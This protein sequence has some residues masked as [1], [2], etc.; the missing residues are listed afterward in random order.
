MTLAKVASF[1]VDLDASGDLA[2]FATQEVDAVLL[3]LRN[4][5]PKS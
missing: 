3:A 1:H 5:A 2:W 4:T